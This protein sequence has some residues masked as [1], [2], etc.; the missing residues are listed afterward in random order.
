MDHVYLFQYMVICV[1]TNMKLLIRYTCFNIWY[2]LLVWQH[3][4][5]DTE[6][7]IYMW[8]CVYEL[9]FFWLKCLL[10]TW[11]CLLP[12]ISKE[13]VG[14][15]SKSGP[16][17]YPRPGA[18]KVRLRG[19]CPKEF[20][21][22]FPTLIWKE[23]NDLEGL[24]AQ[25]SRRPPRQQSTDLFSGEESGIRSSISGSFT[26]ECGISDLKDEQFPCLVAK[27]PFIDQITSFCP[28]IHPSFQPGMSTWRY[29]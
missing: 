21:C 16:Q 3:N 14:S 26:Q 24:I 25:A 20:C 29:W 28:H 18:I 12:P 7:T 10:K 2:G 17:V 5:P 6:C 19:A 15:T 9:M 27:A 23:E 1:I 8:L 11:T 22:K 4:M 13:T